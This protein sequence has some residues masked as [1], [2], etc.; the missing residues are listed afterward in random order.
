LA[1]GN[2]TIAVGSDDETIDVSVNVTFNK[3]YLY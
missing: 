3:T 2:N 1:K